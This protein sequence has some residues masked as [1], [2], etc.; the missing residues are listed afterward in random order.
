MEIR[1]VLIINEKLSLHK[2]LGGAKGYDY[3]RSHNFP[4]V[5]KAV[6]SKAQWAMIAAFVGRG[7]FGYVLLARQSSF[8]SAQSPAVGPVVLKVDHRHQFVVWE[9]TLHARV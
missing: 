2:A 4:A 9:A 3:D 8:Q 6:L 1:P 7:T 5:K